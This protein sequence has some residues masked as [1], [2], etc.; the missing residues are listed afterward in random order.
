MAAYGR[1][2]CKSRRR[3]C[4]AQEW[5]QNCDRDESMLRCCAPLRI[6]VA[7]YGP[8]NPFATISAQRGLQAPTSQ[9]LLTDRERTYGPEGLMSESCQERTWMLLPR[10]ELQAGLA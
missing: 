9:G 3:R 8:Q 7:R 5:N 6:N 10:F 1:F 2:C 4:L